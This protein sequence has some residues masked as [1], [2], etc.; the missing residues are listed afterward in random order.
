MI[1]NIILVSLFVSAIQSFGQSLDFIARGNLSI[2]SKYE[3]LDYSGAD[4]FYSPGGGMGIELGLQWKLVEN[5]YFQSSLGYQLNLALQTESFNGI[6]N[7]SSF[8][9]GRTFLSTGITKKFFIS[10]DLFNGIMLGGGVQ[11]SLPS[12]LTRIENETDLGSSR[13]KANLGYFIDLGVRLRMSETVFLE[14][15]IRYRNLRLDGKSYNQGAIDD[16]P[17]ALQNLNANGVELGLSLIK[18][19]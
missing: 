8:S 18:N 13:Y 16:L 6:T 10:E 2:G 15:G 11:Y 5:L 7:K 14:P 4:M 19:I 9:F 17:P 1:K 12:S 3:T